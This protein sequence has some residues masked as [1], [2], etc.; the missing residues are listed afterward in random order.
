M[1]EV[2]DEPGTSRKTLSSTRPFLAQTL[3]RLNLD[4]DKNPSSS[5]RFC[6]DANET[7]K[8]LELSPHVTKKWFRF[9][10]AKVSPA[11]SIVGPNSKPKIDNA[12]ILQK[13]LRSSI[14]FKKGMYCKEV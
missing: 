5:S 14:I 7:P 10:T 12:G 4:S 2:R 11:P 9:N 1:N 3:H 13:V 6:L 8:T